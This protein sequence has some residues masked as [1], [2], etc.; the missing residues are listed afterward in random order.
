MLTFGQASTF[1]LTGSSG[2]TELYIQGGTALATVTLAV[3]DSTDTIGVADDGSVAITNFQA[4]ASGD[5]IAIDV[6]ATGTGSKITDAGNDNDVA[7]GD[8]V[9]LTEL[10]AATDLSA[11]SKN[12]NVLVITGITF[13]TTALV[14][15]ALES[16]GSRALNVDVDAGDELIVVWSD[17]SNSYVG[18]LDVGTATDG[19]LAAGD[20]TMTILAELVGV[21]ASTASTLVAANF[22][23]I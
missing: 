4:G 20:T 13:A 8:A 7:A 3:Q 23:F 12:D 14:E 19:T 18:L 22:S 9:V 21:D 5:K 6:S 15:T 16:G 1:D 2:T 17:G 10:S 11:A